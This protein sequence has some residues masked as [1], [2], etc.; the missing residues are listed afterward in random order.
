MTVVRKKIYL[1]YM[2]TMYCPKNVNKTFILIIFPNNVYLLLE[3]DLEKEQ[4]MYMGKDRIKMEA[5]LKSIKKEA[6]IKKHKNT[7]LE[8]YSISEDGIKP[9]LQSPFY[10]LLSSK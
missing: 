4:P 9:V 10:S 6:D 5:I 8:V 1:L 3:T 2:T 7:S